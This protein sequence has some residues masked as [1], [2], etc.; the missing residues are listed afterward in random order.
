MAHAKI[1]QRNTPRHI[2]L[3]LTEGEADFILGVLGNVGGHPAKSPRKYADRIVK[4][5]HRVSG[6]HFTET[7]SFQLSNGHL[8]CFEY[9]SAPPLISERLNAFI[10][11]A[12]HLPDEPHIRDAVEDGKHILAMIRLS[13]AEDG[14][15]KPVTLAEAREVELAEDARVAEIDALRE[16]FLARMRK[17]DADLLAATRAKREAATIPEPEYVHMEWEADPL[18]GYPRVL[19][20]E[21]ATRAKRE[22]EALAILRAKLTNNGR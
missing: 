7:D 17:P 22:Q 1:K 8:E 11:M 3:T 19:D 14:P 2:V 13:Q 5:L 21:D 6:Y 20:D 10:G 18:A 9:G 4:A 15:V 16:A 12:K